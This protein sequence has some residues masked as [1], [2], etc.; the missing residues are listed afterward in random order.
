M[1]FGSLISDSQA[2]GKVFKVY[3]WCS[4][5]AAEEFSATSG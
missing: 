2:K 1:F 3:G 4:W 5:Q